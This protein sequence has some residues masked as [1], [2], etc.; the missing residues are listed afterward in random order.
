MSSIEKLAFVNVACCQFK[1]IGFGYTIHKCFPFLEPLK[2]IL[3]FQLWHRGKK[4]ISL[5]ISIM[6]LPTIVCSS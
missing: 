2:N 5:H 1:Y 3:L 6:S 4:I